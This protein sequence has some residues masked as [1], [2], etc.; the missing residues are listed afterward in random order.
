MIEVVRG[1]FVRDGPLLMVQ[2]TGGS[3]SGDR[4]DAHRHTHLEGAK[5]TPLPIFNGIGASAELLE[6]LGQADFVH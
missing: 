5:G 4:S 6:P 3:R 1:L 2:R